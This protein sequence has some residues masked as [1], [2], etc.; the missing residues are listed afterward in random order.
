MT[1][2]RS[3]I[4]SGSLREHMDN[5]LLT[6]EELEQRLRET[7]E[8]VAALRRHEVDAIVGEKSVAVVRL[9]EVEQQLAAAR[10]SA[11]LR[12]AELEAFS[13]S[14]SHEF[15]NPLNNIS[16]MVEVLESCCADTLDEDGHKCIGLIRTNATRMAEMISGLLE[17]SQV[18]RREI[19]LSDVDL[20]AMVED[21]VMELR[22]LAPDRRVEVIVQKGLHVVADREM[23]KM[24]VEN[25]LRNAWK[26]TSKTPDARIEV[27]MRTQ[28][29]TR[30]FFVRDNGPGF[31][32]KHA[33]RIFEQFQRVHP[34]SEYHGT[35]I[36]LSIVKRVIQRHNGRIWA[37]SQ[38]GKGATFF[39][40][41]GENE[42]G[43][44]T[45]G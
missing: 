20:T 6:Y 30:V 4:V 8:M 12:A 5:A 26:F 22:I 28:D 32:M 33:E 10:K 36:G 45:Q 19:S 40:T 25:V 18:V 43:G 2:P 11:E 31:E 16:A 13:H 1:G 7:E 41:L 23:L 29:S 27:G 21:F 39:F 9:R 3:R 44:G 42:R 24:A 15:R 17:L 37:E 35:G 34:Q 38:P 14:V